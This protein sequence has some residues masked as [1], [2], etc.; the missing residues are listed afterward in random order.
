MRLTNYMTEKKTLDA[1]ETSRE[2][3]KLEKMKS[4]EEK[5]NAIVKLMDDMDAV[6]RVLFL[7]IKKKAKKG[8]KP[9]NEFER[10]HS[11]FVNA[12]AALADKKGNTKSVMRLYQHWINVTNGI[13]N[14]KIK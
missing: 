6:K 1:N 4:G 10:A 9:Y 3:K 8:S 5:D 13:I 11:V 2:L 14:D 7:T 12:V